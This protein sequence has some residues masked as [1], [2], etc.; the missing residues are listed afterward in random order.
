MK[1]IDKFSWDHY[2]QRIGHNK[3]QILPTVEN[4]FAIVN[5]HVMSIPYQ[6][7]KYHKLAAELVDLSISAIQNRLVHQAL[8]GMC[9]E[10][11]ELLYAALTSIGFRVERIPVVTLNNKP[12]RKLTP[13]TH[14]ILIAYVA[15]KKYLID[16]GFGYNSIRFPLEFCFIETETTTISE[17]EKYQLCCEDDHYQLNMWKDD[18]WFSC[19]CFTKPLCGI[20]HMQLLQNYYE[21]QLFQGV[22]PIRDLF[23]V[24]GILVPT[25][26]VGYHCE[27]RNEQVFLV[28][29]LVEND[30]V[31]KKNYHSLTDFLHDIQKHLQLTMPDKL[32]QK[33]QEREFSVEV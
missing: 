10:T 32:I 27:L 15:E 12:W 20:N 16:V 25:G 26:R 21:A 28:Q 17:P 9:L 7:F 19:Y 14:N 2:C 3:L 31:H 8:G 23:L 11:S 33:L 18:M 6:N 22:L 30:Q 29:I 5:R 1:Q 13:S 4:L 24:A